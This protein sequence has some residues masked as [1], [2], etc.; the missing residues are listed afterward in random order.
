MAEILE[1]KE[2][3]SLKRVWDPTHSPLG[4]HV[5]APCDSFTY[6]M[7]T[8]WSKLRNFVF[9]SFF[10][11]FSLFFFFRSTTVVYYSNDSFP[12]PGCKSKAG[13]LPSWRHLPHLPLWGNSTWPW[14]P[15]TSECI[16]L[17]FWTSARFPLKMLR[18]VSRPPHSLPVQPAERFPLSCNSEINRI[19]SK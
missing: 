18:A 17:D 13:C 6:S 2:S 19:G 15:K 12:Q 11:S 4:E 3:R 14:T 7:P 5:A 1:A 10:L 16:Y 9:F 8:C